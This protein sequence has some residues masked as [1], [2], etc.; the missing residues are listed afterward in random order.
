MTLQGQE[1]IR[2]TSKTL[3][4]QPGVYQMEDIK[5]NILYIGK[6]KNLS[7]RVKN[8]LSINNLSIRIQRMVSLTNSMNFFVTNT[9]V[10]VH[11]KLLAI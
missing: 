2:A 4:N 7:N 3:P 10:K 11:I 1:I 5:G 9:L 8:Y 6:A